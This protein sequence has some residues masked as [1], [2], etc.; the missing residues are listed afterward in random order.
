MVAL[1]RNFTGIDLYEEN[2]Q[3][4]KINIKECL[5]G[6]IKVKFDTE[7]LEN[8]PELQIQSLEKFLISG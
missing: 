1:Q 7:E 3:N 8:A 5:A 2:V 4:S 6:K